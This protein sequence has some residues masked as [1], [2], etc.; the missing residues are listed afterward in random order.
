MASH[1]HSR[2]TAPPAD[3]LPQFSNSRP[4]V[5]GPLLATHRS[6][7]ARDLACILD[8]NPDVLAWSCSP[9]PLRTERGEHLADFQVQDTA[10]GSW[11]LDAPDRKAHCSSEELFEAAKTQAIHYRVVPG[12]EIYDGF[13]LRNAKDLLRYSGYNVPLGERVRLLSALDE[14]G[15][16]SFADCLRAMREGQPVAALASMILQG[17]VEVELDD[18]LIGPETMVRRIRR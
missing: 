16:L 17:L 6:K 18:A 12:G 10:G 3:R 14:Q 7:V 13:R 5:K 8:L 15:P 11:L 2:Q 1:D 9:P 4:P